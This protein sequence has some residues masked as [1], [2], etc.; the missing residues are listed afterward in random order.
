MMES[1]Y[2]VVVIGYN[3]LY[4]LKRLCDSLKRTDFL[5]DSV[6]LIISLD[7]WED[8]SLY[9]F[10]KGFQWDFGE[11]KVIFHEEKMGLRRHILSCGFFLDEYEALAILEDDIFVSPGFY[12]YMKQAVQFYEKCDDIAG[13]SLYSFERNS[14]DG[15]RF[16]PVQSAYDTFFM[17]MAQSWGQI[18][19]RRQWKQFYSWYLENEG[20][21]VLAELHIPKAIKGW[22]D[23]SWLKY[24]TAYC[25]Q[26]GKFF[27]YPYHALTTC[28]TEAGVHVKYSDITCQVALYPNHR[29]DYN[30]ASFNVQAIKYDV[31][32]ERMD[33]EKYIP[34]ITENQ[35]VCVDLYGDKYRFDGY[36]HLL[37][38]KELKHVPLINAYALQLKPQEL[39]VIFEIVGKDIYLYAIE[40]MD[41][42]KITV[43][44]NKWKR[45]EYFSAPKLTTDF[46]MMIMYFR[47]LCNKY[48]FRHRKIR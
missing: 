23:S 43:K 5:G 11:K 36:T 35:R 30:F 48:I 29:R 12:S 7:F 28:F 47:K 22:G 17:Q 1:R 18:W 33:M 40:D 2:A 39:N 27:V 45:L 15:L 42:K 14:Y 19:L 24:H 8:R 38:T 21:D 16:E 6:D 10:S 13:I 37:T 25:V 46:G 20:Q 34:E 9:D 32:Y 4:S 41:L 26:K 3:R 31:F 44:N